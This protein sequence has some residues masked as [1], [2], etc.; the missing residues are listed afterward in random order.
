MC[1]ADKAKVHFLSP[2]QFYWDVKNWEFYWMS[3]NLLS[4]SVN[5]NICIFESCT[6]NHILF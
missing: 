2:D 1:P 6:Y 4:Q 3:Y 5:L